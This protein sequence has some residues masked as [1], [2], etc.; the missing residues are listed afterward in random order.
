MPAREPQCAGYIEVKILGGKLSGSACAFLLVG[1][2]GGCAVA[3]LEP[4][5]PRPFGEI[6]HEDR[7]V[8][9][10]VHDTTIDLRTGQVRGLRT[11]APMVPAGPF[12]ISVPITIGG[13]KKKQVPAEEITVRLPSG[14]LVFVVQE[15][16]HPAFAVGEQVR[17]LHEKPHY[18][19]G[20]SRTRIAR[21]E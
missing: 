18:I 3:Q 19:S 14:K 21:V 10:S 5:P 12:G 15:Q 20:E 11:S 8:I 13:E 4:A 6:D 7:G 16:S 1:C 2:L 9:A 17:V